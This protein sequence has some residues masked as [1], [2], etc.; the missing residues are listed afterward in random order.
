MNDKYWRIHEV[1]FLA[2]NSLLKTKKRKMKKKIYKISIVLCFMILSA[3]QGNMKNC[4]EGMRDKGYSSD[5]AWEACEDA[6]YES[7]IR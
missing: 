7:Q 3:C 2:I 5:E 4:V 6:K 1:P